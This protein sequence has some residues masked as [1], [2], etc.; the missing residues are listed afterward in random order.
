M[1]IK[2]YAYARMAALVAIIFC[3]GTNVLKAQIITTIA[4]IGNA[5]GYQA[6]NVGIGYVYGIAS[7][8]AGNLYFTS[9]GANG[10][11]IRKV[12]A[13]N[14]KL[15]SVAVS[16]FKDSTGFGYDLGGLTVDSIGNI[17]FA[18]RYRYRI[19]K[20]SV[21]GVVTTIAG[22]GSYGDT[23]DS[24]LA[25]QAQLKDP[26]GVAI[27][28]KGNIFIADNYKIRKVDK[29]G[30]I[31]TVVGG[32]SDTWAEGGVATN[33][34]G[35]NYNQTLAID[36]KGCIYTTAFSSVYKVD[37]AGIIHLV[38]GD[39]NATSIGDGGLAKNAQLSDQLAIN[40][41]A[42]DNLFI[43]D[44]RNHRIRKV[45]TLGIIST[46]AGN[47]INAPATDG[48]IASQNSIGLSGLWDA[49][50]KV[51]FGRA[52][53]FYFVEAYDTLLYSSQGSNDYGITHFRIKHVGSTGV[54]GTA[55]GN[56][57]SALNGENIAATQ[58]QVSGWGLATDNKGNIYYAASN[59][60]RIRK[61]NTSGI[62]ATYAG[63]GLQGLSGDG[64][65]ALKAP[66]ED[67]ESIATDSSGNLFICDQGLS[68]IRKVAANGIITTIAGIDSNWNGGFNG[69]SI[70]AVNAR[71]NYPSGISIDA[72]G[73]VYFVDQNNHRIRKINTKG[74]IT[75]IAGNGQRGHAGDGGLAINAQIGSPFA[76]AIDKKGNLYFSDPDTN[77]IRKV[78][79][80]GIITTIAGNGNIGYSGD[81]GMAK[82]ALLSAPAGLAIAPNGVLF[83]ADAYNNVIRK[84]DSL[85]IIT[86]VVG[87]GGTGFSGDG[88]LAKNAQLNLPISI[89]LDNAG[90]LIIS[91]YGNYRI[92][93]VTPAPLPLMLLSFTA[94]AAN[95]AIQTEWQTTTETNTSHFK[96]EHSIDGK[97]FTTIGTVAAIGSGA[98]SYAFTDNNPAD[99][100]NYYRLQMVDKDGSFSYSKLVAVVLTTHY[101]PLTISPNPAKD[102]TTISFTQSVDKATI[103]VYN[104]SG[105][106]VIT[107]MLSGVTN[108][109][110]LNTQSLSNGV[111]VLKVTTGTG[112]YNEKL[113]INK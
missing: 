12:L 57:T 88:G 102:F 81:G 42:K 75:T 112:S 56:G 2:F 60:S 80:K 17:F 89:A 40:I 52:N 29:N 64:G 107:Q 38:A 87:K 21:S 54:V 74:I 45:D 76:T 28:A 32:G 95:Y 5:D 53:D 79:T 101:S 84:I 98:N 14:G 7:D 39:I 8:K 104:M 51:A 109:Y 50:G 41:D 46:V 71:L 35:Y 94:K 55:A 34:G 73:N 19:R 18:D 110:K 24:G 66:L 9:D 1:K 44:Y 27:D 20:I 100:T 33:V 91:D 99:G 26:Y 6:A 82:F 58:A 92:R 63:N 105:K 103:A 15:S 43:T 111:Y 65:Q 61:I 72:A 83:F 70:L 31:T 77:I 59:D 25:T 86:T 16:T 90:N 67:P 106:V 13:S 22:N 68:R 11:A 113:L 108:A 62:V 85:G 69:D 3:S 97:G 48:T 36:S 4:G 93:K 96:V 30:I 23:G 37:T 10:G 78:D 47:G 49:E